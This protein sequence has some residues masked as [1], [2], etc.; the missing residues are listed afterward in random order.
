M[1]LHLRL[2]C[3]LS[4]LSCLT[5]PTAASSAHA[6]A[7]ATTG[8]PTTIIAIVGDSAINPLHVEFRT[9]DGRD[10]AYPRWMPKPIR[11]PQPHART[12][13]AAITELESG[14]LGHPQ[15]GALYALAGTRLLIYATPG[16]SNLIDDGK[17]PQGDVR[18]HGTGTAAAAVGLKTGTSPDSLIVFVPSA[19]EPAYGWIAKQRW[20]DVASTSAYDIPTTGQC[21]G[22]AGARALYRDGGLLFSSAGNTADYYEP[23][24]APNGLPEVFQVGGVDSTGRTWLPGHTD[25]GSPFFTAGSVVR[26]YEVGAR[27]SFN[28]AGPDSYSGQQLFGGTSGATPTVAG[29]AADLIAEARRL[30]G[31]TGPRTDTA[32]ATLSPGRRA[33]RTG[34][35]SDGRLT[36]DELVS[37]LHHTAI[38]HETPSSGRYDLEGYGAATQ[39]SLRLGLRVLQGQTHEP[40]RP[41]ED[42]ANQQAEALRGQLTSRC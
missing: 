18:A 15:P 24:S 32:L 23:L 42:R 4:A 5:G 35:L 19:G 31:S 16:I 30:L 11:I 29:Y 8:R 10:P 22:D 14:P 41:D 26:P 9:H 33:P 1:K 20:I 25:A 3:A 7:P 36:R 39:E 17:D 21:D 40:S 28:S 27:Y 34:L 6:A 37:L 2:A 13:A 38:P 12:F